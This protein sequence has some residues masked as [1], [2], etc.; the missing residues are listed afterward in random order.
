M[1]KHSIIVHPENLILKASPGT[2]LIDV[3]KD[4]GIFLNLPCGG[5]GRC[6][7]CV[8][9]VISGANEPSDDEKKH[10][11]AKDIDEGMRLACRT[12]IQSDI[13]ISV[14]TSSRLAGA[15]AGWE[16][17]EIA[18]GESVSG[19]LSLAIDLGT[20]SIAVAL[21]NQDGRVIAHASALN[22]QVSYGADV[23]SRINAISK[24]PDALP[25]QQG[26]VIDA[27]NVLIKKLTDKTGAELNNLKS[28][29]LCGNPTMEHLFLGIDPTPIA[30]APFTP[31]F[32]KAQIVRAKDIGI[33][34]YPEGEIYV[35]PVL[36]GYV[37]GD[38]LGF[39]WSSRIH[40]SDAI[41]MG[42]DIGTNGE[43]VLG[44][45]KHLYTC[46]TAAG[47]AF[48]GA[49]IRDGMRADRGAIEGVTISG[50]GISDIRVDI[51][52]KGGGKPRGICGSGIF[53]AVAEMIRVG[54]INTSGRITN[55][56]I[57]NEEASDKRIRR[58]DGVLEFLLHNDNSNPISITQKDIREVQLAKGA[59]SAGA[60]VLM[61]EMGIGWGDIGT[62]LIAGAFGNYLKVKSIVGVGLVPET[63]KEKIRFVGDAA[64]S[65]AVE[66]SFNPNARQ[67]IEELT[68]KINYVELSSDR[69]FNDIFMKRLSF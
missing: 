62:L 66:A 45:G 60:E 2:P 37:G 6:G 65:G 32:T 16:D 68:K 20:T 11:S 48:E 1:P 24:D 55:A 69:R 35:F 52:I 30:Y 49:Q 36:S 31:V 46:S 14:P 17:I 61:K 27:I 28:M 42:I 40:E 57:A 26:L 4:K 18:S 29:A 3:L 22:P 43:I 54:I 44:N 7:K 51:Q 64:L 9:S 41:I 5:E 13:E 39:I 34:I 23:I 38:T 59:M 33:S 50:G 21:V 53:D 25:L 10:L 47:P 63:L 12:N 19:D 15:G 58:T 56:R 67:K 8:V